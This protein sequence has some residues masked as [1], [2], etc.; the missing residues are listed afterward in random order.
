MIKK[1]LAVLILFLIPLMVCAEET[2]NKV[3]VIM[4][5]INLKSDKTGLHLAEA[6]RKINKDSYIIFTTGHLE[7]AMIA[8]KFKTF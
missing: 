8:Y 7:Y 1:T 3:D 2:N 6:I 5:D 4:L